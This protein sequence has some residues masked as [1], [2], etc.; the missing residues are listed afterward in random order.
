MK[1]TNKLIS[2]LLAV[3]MMLTMASLSFT[4]SAASGT[5]GQNA[6]WS[7]NKGVLT[8]SGSGAMTDYG[9]SKDIPWYNEKDN[10]TKVV[11]ES[12]ITWLDQESFKACYSMTSAEIKG[13]TTLTNYSFA[14]CGQLTSVVF[15]GTVGK[16]TGTDAFEGCKNLTSFT[17]REGVGKSGNTF[18]GCKRMNVKLVDA[19]GNDKTAYYTVHVEDDTMY[20][21]FMTIT[22]NLEKARLPLFPTSL[23]PVL[24]SCLPLPLIGTD[25][26]F[27]AVTIILL[28]AITLKRAQQPLP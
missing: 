19:G 28:T 18:L 3:A 21:N 20:Y 1:K 26:L 13:N 9:S 25:R 5:C 22:G 24:Q 15:G 2:V 11:V 10:I 23:I 14:Y 16:I 7:L 27:R 12:G 6:T 4:A 17:L 8:I